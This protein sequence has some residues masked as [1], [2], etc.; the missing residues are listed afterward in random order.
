ML[1]NN[2][3]VSVGL[4]VL[5]GC[6]HINIIYCFILIVLLFLYWISG[7]ILASTVAIKVHH[8]A[9]FQEKFLGKKTIL[10]NIHLLGSW[11]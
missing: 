2:K 10:L 9:A 11:S 3:W 8:F 5:D 6:F 7:L 4:A 1:R